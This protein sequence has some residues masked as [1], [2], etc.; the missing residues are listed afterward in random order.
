VCAVLD[1]NVDPVKMYD[2]QHESQKARRD[3]QWKSENAISSAVHSSIRIRS[4]CN[5]Q[6]GITFLFSFS[7]ILNTMCCIFTGVRSSSLD[8]EINGSSR[9]NLRYCNPSNSADA[10]GRLFATVGAVTADAAGRAVDQ[11]HP[12]SNHLLHSLVKDCTFELI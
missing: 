9:K 3:C 11:D 12:Q 4:V 8:F 1:S 5:I 6:I 2:L 10:A 7:R